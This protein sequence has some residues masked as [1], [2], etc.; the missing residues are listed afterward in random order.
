[1]VS[2]YKYSFLDSADEIERK[3]EKERIE[4]KPISE[5]SSSALRG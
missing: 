2:K 3:K 5:L 4:S 1:M